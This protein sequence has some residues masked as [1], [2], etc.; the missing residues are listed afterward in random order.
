MHLQKQ[1]VSPWNLNF[2]AN[3]SLKILMI[4]LVDGLRNYVTFATDDGYQM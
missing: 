4:N 3:D 1:H 2:G